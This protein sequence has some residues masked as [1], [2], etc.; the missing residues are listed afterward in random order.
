MPN[1]HPGAHT[2]CLDDHISSN[3]RGKHHLRRRTHHR[4]TFIF[5]DD[6]EHESVEDDEQFIDRDTLM[7]ISPRYT[8]R[9]R[10]IKTPDYPVDVSKH[11]DTRTINVFTRV[12]SPVRPKSLPMYYLWGPEKRVG[13]VHDHFGDVGYEKIHWAVD[14]LRELHGFARFVKVTWVCDTVIDRLHCM[15]EEQFILR[16]ASGSMQ[17][18]SG[19]IEIDGEEQF[20]G[21]QLPTVSDLEYCSLTPDDFETE[22]LAQLAEE[23]AAFPTLAFIA[24]VMYALGG[25]PDAAWMKKAPKLAR[26]VFSHAGSY[27][28][29][30]GASCSE[31]CAQYHHHAEDE[32]CYAA[33]P[34][35][36]AQHFVDQLYTASSTD[37][38]VTFSHAQAAMNSRSIKY[39]TIQ[40]LKEANSPPE[41]LDVEKMILE[42][43]IRLEEAKTAIR[44]AHAAEPEEKEPSMRAA[45]RMAQSV[46][47]PVDN[48]QK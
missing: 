46:Y 16:K 17:N 35:N 37:K 40:Q 20:I 7:E 28:C 43:E 26:N 8:R 10:A 47:K 27:D 24:N 45:K 32:R 42:M 30:I 22:L 25:A 23:P 29:L 41:M 12:V 1:S 19:R 2:P 9:S 13:G 39:G 3:Y 44:M 5:E 4:V 48:M 36:T 21:R 11:F 33:T 38:I 31:F 34:G 15:F 6:E 18:R 14:N